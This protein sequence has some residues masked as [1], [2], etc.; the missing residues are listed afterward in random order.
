LQQCRFG[1]LAA[2]RDYDPTKGASFRTFARQR[3]RGVITSHLREQKRHSRCISLFDEVD[4][5]TTGE[6]CPLI[7]VVVGEH[8]PTDRELNIDIAAAKPP[9]PRFLSKLPKKQAEVI[10]LIYWEDLTLS[11]IAAQIGCT[12]QRVH[13]IAK[14]ALAFLRKQFATERFLIGGIGT[15]A[16]GQN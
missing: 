10:R 14:K 13:A 11:Q 6:R 15:P 1:L 16:F 7:D 9:L 8:P 4:L 2:H 12:K 5:G 3:L